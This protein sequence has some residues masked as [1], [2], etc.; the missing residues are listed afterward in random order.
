MPGRPLRATFAHTPG[1]CGLAALPSGEHA[2]TTGSDSTLRLHDI[3]DAPAAWWRS[4]AAEEP[5]LPD[6]PVTDLHEKAV[7]TLAVSPTGATFA[8]G[9]DDGF[10][11]LFSVRDRPAVHAELVQACARFGGP[12]RAVHFSPTGAFL[13]AAGDEPGV[14]KIIMTAQPSN[15]TV[16]RAP[17][18]SPAS[19]AIAGL[20]FDPSGDFVATLGE[21]G[22]A[23]IWDVEKCKMACTVDL[24][25]RKA[26]CVEWAPAGARLIFGTDKGIVV[27]ARGTWAFDHLLE[28]AGEDDDDGIYAATSGKD[29]I[30][31]LACSSNGRYLLAAREDAGISLW[32]THM[33]KLLACWKGSEVMQ[34]LLWHPKA[35]AM[36]MIDKIGQ[37][38]LASDVVP[39]HM[40][41]PHADAPTLEL[42]DLPETGSKPKK[43][44]K[45]L[46]V[47]FGDDEENGGDV[48]R[49]KGAKLRKLKQQERRKK[50]KAAKESKKKRDEESDKDEEDN[51]LENGFTFNTSEVEADDED[52]LKSREDESGS[53]DDESGS[54]EEVPGELADLENAGFRLPA[55]KRRSRSRLEGSRLSSLPAVVAQDPFMPTSTPL[56]EKETKKKR[57]LAWNLVGAVLSFDESTHDVVEI[58]FAD[59]SKRTIGIKDHYGY[60]MGCLTS[61]G[62]LLASPKKKEHGS[63]ITFRPFSSWSNNSDWTQFLPADEDISIIALGQRFAAAISTPN[64]VVRIFSLSGI[65]TSVFGIPGSVVTAAANGDKLVIVYAEAGSSFLRC[66]LLDISTLG[67]VEKVRYSGSL[68]LCPGSKLEWIGFTNDTKELCTYDSKGWLW[69]MIDPK[70]TRRWVP[71]MQNAA[72]TGECDWFWVA[73]ATSTNLIGAPCLSNERYPP[74]KPRPALRSLLLSAPVIE[75]VTKS[76]KPTVIERFLRTKLRLNRANAAKVDA[77]EMFDS[78]DEEV[79]NAEDVVARMEVETDKCTLALMEE[80][81]RNEQNMRAFDLAS[82]LHAKISFKYAVE[83][84]KHFKRAAL[85]S[86]VEQ[87]AMRKIELMEEDERVRAGLKQDLT[88]SPMTPNGTGRIGSEEVQFHESQDVAQTRSKV[89]PSTGKAFVTFDSDDDNLVVTKKDEKAAD[90]GVT[91]VTDDE[92]EAPNTTE[93]VREAETAKEPAEKEPARKESGRK[94][95]SA[96]KPADQ[97]K[98]K[99]KAPMPESQASVKGVDKDPSTPVSK[100]KKTG[101]FAKTNGDANAKKKFHNRF[102][103]K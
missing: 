92:E 94:S 32:D 13:A 81:C 97:D 51:G 9:C 40:P 54:D 19:D 22:H 48:K 64:N 41:S 76:G 85:A 86:R 91:D 25:G 72:K 43:K 29:S 1:A 44:S 65:Q 28:D 15:V 100:K 38:G 5:E 84:A 78:D 61:T 95:A 26:R 63:L 3:A 60:T 69:L 73:S 11:R 75:K 20:A 49:S 102:L 30:S 6:L 77:D 59:A 99:R 62:V 8:T 57:I 34:R 39:S 18:G 2:L 96:K 46:E 17:S 66:E 35:N 47:D 14:L 58:E 42:P 50:A 36:I 89:A 16:L 98:R 82:R 45:G 103:K 93:V 71:M 33:K 67:E 52:E 74:A 90:F 87:I 53:S 70:V 80:A 101:A 12:V 7:G 24:Q 56:S 31:A 23:V 79:G 37:W 88:D 10:V 83:L 68:M 55:R 27:V 21:R 4:D